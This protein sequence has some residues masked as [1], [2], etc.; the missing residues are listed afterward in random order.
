[1]SLA[2]WLHPANL[3]DCAR[4]ILARA[5]RAWFGPMLLPG[6]A[7]TIIEAGIDRT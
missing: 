1:M 6:D 7:D 5:S 2:L 3:A 4:A